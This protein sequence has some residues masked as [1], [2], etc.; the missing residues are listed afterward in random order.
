MCSARA[1]PPRWRILMLAASSALLLG[2]DAAPRASDT[3]AILASIA[4]A[5]GG[6]AAVERLDAF[7]IEGEVRA[8]VRGETA[9]VRRD[10]LGADRLRVTLEYPGRTEVRILQG[11][12]GWRGTEA[13]QLPVA[14]LPH[15]AMVYQLIRSTVPRSLMH[16]RS[17]IVQ[18]GVRTEAGGRYLLL[19]F[20]GKQGL[21]IDFWVEDISRRVTRVEG[22]LASDTVKM[23]FATRY[24]DFRDV[25]GLLFPHSEENLVG[26]RHAGSTT[27]QSVS[28]SAGDLGPFAPD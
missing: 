13:E 12:R 8:H 6:P 7:R 21:S 28:F 24:G 18:A 2:A 3:D 5:Y 22:T 4:R 23:S 27:I 15:L 20:D 14:G 11:E 16:H 26:G 1:R 10:V 25:D 9:R 19:R 17:H